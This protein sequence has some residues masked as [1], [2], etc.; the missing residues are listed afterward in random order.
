MRHAADIFTGVGSFRDEG[1][2]AERVGA[3]GRV[4][5][6][7]DEAATFM[8]NA[9]ATDTAMKSA[10]DLAAAEHWAEA[11]VAQGANQGQQSLMQGITSGVQ[12]LVGSFGSMG[13]GG[14]FGQAPQTVNAASSSSSWGGMSDYMSGLRNNVGYSDPGGNFGRSVLTSGNDYG[15]WNG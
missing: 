2:D 13:G 7:E 15:I 5:Q 14:G 9:E 1:F 3:E 12:G 11:T 6:A 4:V 10:S 8:R